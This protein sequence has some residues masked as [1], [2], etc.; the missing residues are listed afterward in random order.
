MLCIICS[1]PIPIPIYRDEH[2]LCKSC[3]SHIKLKG[4]LMNDICKDDDLENVQ[5]QLLL[6]LNLEEDSDYEAELN[7]LMEAKRTLALRKQKN[8]QSFVSAD[9]LKEDF[10]V[11]EKVTKPTVNI[12]SFINFDFTLKRENY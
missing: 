8:V 5:Q 7:Y 12:N 4:N 9:S 1:R 3:A 2:K 6:D 10:P 11:V